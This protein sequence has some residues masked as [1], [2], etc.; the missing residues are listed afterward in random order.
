MVVAILISIA[1]A[2]IAIVA[3]RRADRALRAAEHLRKTLAEEWEAERRRRARTSEPAPRAMPEPTAPLTPSAAPT[4]PAPTTS[5]PPAYSPPGPVPDP[6]RPIQELTAAMK[7]EGASRPSADAAPPSLHRDEP[8]TGSAPRGLRIQPVPLPSEDAVA[9][10]AAAAIAP[11]PPSPPAEPSPPMAASPVM[12]AIPVTAAPAPVI[13]QPAPLAAASAPRRTWEQRIGEQ[14]LTIVGVGILVLGGAFFLKFGWDQGWF[15]NLLTARVKLAL[16]AAGAIAFAITGWRLL[17]GM[18]A[19]GQGL[20][21]AGLSFGYLTV[22]AGAKGHLIGE[23][24]LPG[25]LAIA[26]A[27]LITAIGLGFAAWRGLLPL[28]IGAMLGGFAAPALLSDGGGSRAGL[29]AYL[30]VLALGVL[31][32]AWWRRWRAL[33]VVAFSATAI[34][35]GLWQW[36]GRG[37]SVGGMAAW[38][39]CFHGIFLAVPFAWHWRTRTPVTLER[40]IL[41][42]ANAAFS[43]GLLGPLLGTGWALGLIC[44]AA[45]GVYA[46]IGL[47]MARRCGDDAVLRHGFLALA[48][49]LVTLGLLV[50]MP[51]ETRPIAWLAEAV[52]LVW[53]GWRFAYAPARWGGTVL[54]AIAGIDLLAVGPAPAATVGMPLLNPTLAG[55]LCLCAALAAVAALHRRWTGVPTRERLEA[56]LEA[57]W[58]LLAAHAAGLGVLLAVAGDLWRHAAL[59]AWTW[60]IDASIA[61]LWTGGGVLLGWLWRRWRVPGSS[62]IAAA[63]LAGAAGAGLAGYLDAWTWSLPWLNPQAPLALAPLA[64]LAWLGWRFHREGRR[65][66]AEA[67][68]GLGLLYLAAATT[69]EAIAW[70][71][72]SDSTGLVLAQRLAALW[73][74]LSALAGLAA[75]AWRRLLPGLVGLP[76]LLASAF[77]I[78]A[79]YG[80]GP[81]IGTIPVANASCWLMLAW[82]ALCGLHGLWLE[83]LAHRALAQAMLILALVALMGGCALEAATHGDGTWIP[84]CISLSWSVIAVALVAGPWRRLSGLAIL[85]LVTAVLATVLG[86]FAYANEI[87][88]DAVLP[89]ALPLLNLRIVPLIAGLA[90][91]V[92]LG[93]WSQAGLR[94]A[95]WWLAGVLG[96]LLITIDPPAW[97]ALAIA[98][99]G[100]ARRIGLFSVTAAWLLTASTLLAAG[101]HWRRRLLRWLAL[102]LFAVTAAK[103]LL[104]DMAGAQQVWRIIAFFSTGLVLIAAS[105]A[106]HRLATALSRDDDADPRR[107]ADPG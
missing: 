87:V 53:L 20:M 80:L 14:W 103:I 63:A 32:V 95:G 54:I 90:A 61:A 12:A 96:F 64:G 34:Y 86:L 76:L 31:G 5:L 8:R 15:G 77:A 49:M 36:S 43:L 45:A 58:A 83:R 104:F 22:Y 72:G 66:L 39:A 69:A 85:G 29:F 40:F 28:A 50:L 19:L 62:V 73:L 27:A 68:A 98:D 51:I 44:L 23:E 46:A 94:E 11:A 89:A 35:L 107:D 78:L 70:S 30:A 100:D 82:V 81:A 97:A 24:L 102:G 42:L 38:I 101:F 16:M 47:L 56:E 2:I 48:A 57:Q 93:R 33:D 84:W 88:S 60:P 52:V 10:P 55:W 91:F 3:M 59:A 17:A 1:A 21:V 37:G 92:A 18:P 67:A 106:Y 71:L 74:G 9:A 7:A 26:L 75:V 25:A 79:S 99:A 105:F 41:A 13:D 6:W 4:A 65:W